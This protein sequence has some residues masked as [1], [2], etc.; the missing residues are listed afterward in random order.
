MAIALILTAVVGGSLVSGMGFTSATRAGVQSQAAADAGIAAARAGLNTVG[1]CAAQPTPG[2]YVSTVE[3]KYTATLQYNAGAGWQ[4]GCPTGA[5]TQVRIV[6]KGT[7][8]AK[9]LVGRSSGDSSTVEAVVGWLTPGVAPSGIGMYLYKGGLFEA[10]SNL[11]LSEIDGA[12]L[13]VKDGNLDCEKN[14]SKINGNVFVNGNLTFTGSCTVLGDAWVTGTATLGSG[15]IDGDLTAGSVSPTNPKATGQ[16]GGRLNPPGAVAPVVPGWSEVTYKP[17]DWRD[18]SGT[19]YEVKVL[20]GSACKFTNGQR[21]GGTI[22][23]KPV[24]L[25]ALACSNGVE[26]G[27]NDDVVL[28]S[29]VVIFANKF[30]GNNAGS[31]TSSSTAVRRLW[32]ITPDPVPT[33]GKPSCVSPA[34]DF[35]V[36]NKL[37]I[38]APVE[39]FLYTPCKFDAK[40]TFTWNG[41]LYSGEYSDVKNNSGFTFAQMGIAG[42]DLDTGSATTPVLQPKPG[43]LVS[44]RD[45]APVGP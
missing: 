25:N 4:N 10:N 22:P 31:Y 37:E 36:K 23:G 40:N 9:G 44:N 20:S 12:G 1:N 28:T 8:S 39:A 16:V 38:K 3:P 35:V 29:D 42:V 32:F 19:P 26:A 21:I 7:A 15:R 30:T 17:G 2:R 14:N 43:A 24:I 27:N 11:D 34:D 5:T 41:Q 13:M 45:L 6:S 18:E 33:D